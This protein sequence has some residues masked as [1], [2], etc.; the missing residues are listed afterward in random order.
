MAAST[1][2]TASTMINGNRDGWSLPADS[3][4]WKARNA[5]VSPLGSMNSSDMLTTLAK[6]GDTCHDRR[7]GA[8]RTGS[9]A[10]DRGG[11]VGQSNINAV[12][13]ERMSTRAVTVKSRRAAIASL[14]A[15]LAAGVLT[16]C[17]GGPTNAPVAARWTS[18][19]SPP[20]ADED[21]SGPPARPAPTDAFAVG[22]RTLDLNR[23]GQ[24]P[25]AVTVWYPVAGDSARS[26]S[27][28][29]DGRFPVVVFSHG[30]GGLPSDYEP[31]LV[32]WAAAGFVVAAPAYPHTSRGAASTN[33]LDVINQPA[34][35]SYLVTE[36]LA[37]D[38]RPEDP[39]AGHLDVDRVAAAGHSAGGITTVGL[40]TVGRDDRLDAGI[41]LAGSALGVGTAF[42]GAV[43]PQLFV[44]GELDDVVTYA[45]GKAAYDQVP[46]P[47]AMLSL[48]EGDHGQSLFRPGNPAFD[49]VIETTTDFLRWTL[50]GDPAAR[51][52]LSADP[53]T[54]VAVFDNRL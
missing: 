17:G 38:T 7:D 9:S 14:T 43:A 53:P 25:L 39:F 37:R 18:A 11:P 23:G 29:A 51:Q 4:V 47:K 36:L 10:A 48:P 34:D 40:F 6:C 12:T 1:T 24:R 45:S 33:V 42:S 49:V 16:G 20:A 35:A 32:E 5:S 3:D 52:R 44:H 21:G 13:I 30:L 15:L 22:S 54:S 8:V 27:P 2:D 41:V 46:W 28:V 26:G 19:A 31:V 50:Y